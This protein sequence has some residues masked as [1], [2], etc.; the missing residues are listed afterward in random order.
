ME[1][2]LMYI[3]NRRTQFYNEN[4]I[5][6]KDTFTEDDEIECIKWLR[7]IKNPS[8]LKYKR[9]FVPSEVKVKHKNRTLE[10]ISEQDYE[11]FLFTFHPS[12]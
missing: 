8:L 5:L 10:R 12:E 3:L 7:R 9:N 2:F 11:N 4:P 6:K 1:S